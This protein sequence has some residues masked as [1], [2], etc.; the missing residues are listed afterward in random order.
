MYNLLTPWVV[1]A[2]Q[3]E[4]LEKTKEERIHKIARTAS[5]PAWDRFLVRVGDVLISAGLRLHRR[6]QATTYPDPEILRSH[7]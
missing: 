1:E 7:C 3:N 4:L 2:H 6:Y 5:T